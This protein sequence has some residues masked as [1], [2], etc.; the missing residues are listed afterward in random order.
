MRLSVYAAIEGLTTVEL[1]IPCGEGKQ[2]I[3]W[4]VLATSN[5]LSSISC[6]REVFSPHGGFNGISPTDIFKGHP[7]ECLCETLPKSFAH[8]MDSIS[9]HFTDGD[10]LTVHFASKVRINSIG[11]PMISQWGIVAFD[12]SASQ[13]ERR[14]RAI[15]EIE[16]N[17]AELK[18]LATAARLK[19]QQNMF[20][21]KAKSMRS[22]LRSKKLDDETLD[23][24]LKE[25]LLAMHDLKAFVT[26]C[27]SSQIL[28]DVQ[29][30]VKDNYAAANEIYKTCSASTGSEQNS[31]QNSIEQ[32]EFSSFL[33][34]SKIF[35]VRCSMDV[36]CSIFKACLSPRETTPSIRRPG[37][38]VAIVFV[39]WLKFIDGGN[40]TGQ[41]SRQISEEY[42]NK[43]ARASLPLANAV[44]LLFDEYL[45]PLVENGGVGFRAARALDDDEVLACL[46]DY[47]QD[48]R[49]NFER[50]S[51]ARSDNGTMIMKLEDFGTLIDHARLLIKTNEET[52]LNIKE[53]RQAFA[54]AQYEQ[55]NKIN[56]SHMLEMDYQEFIGALIRVAL[57][58]EKK[59]SSSA[60]Y[61]E[62]KSII[63]KVC[64]IT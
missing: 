57:I 59:S 55:L 48:L 56:S 11:R 18:S 35:D 58:K 25:D 64:S 31:A 24:N 29:Q 17:A 62:I 19:E 42:A 30:I 40:K 9:Q 63:S 43:D 15:D 47:E 27:G 1:S 5:R 33:F 6:S 12:I 45:N 50:Y 14:Q 51:S 41:I 3:K 44:K 7:S 34:D 10:S 4:L 2:T 38:L 52:T 22:F 54:G 53:L 36:S 61:E 23:Q 60:C 16:R 39:A 46:H 8:P 21:T 32:A 28:Y 37:F 13:S 49:S 26:L 20:A